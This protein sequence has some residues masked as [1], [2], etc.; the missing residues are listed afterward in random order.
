MN[1][2]LAELIN[3]QIGHCGPEY[4]EQLIRGIRKFGGV[5]VRSRYKTIVLIDGTIRKELKT[6]WLRP[7][8]V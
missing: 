2:R 1:I 5:Y 7:I 8:T 4:R 3:M 6:E